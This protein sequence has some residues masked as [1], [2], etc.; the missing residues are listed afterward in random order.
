MDRDA[1]A[2]DIMRD[3][4]MGHGFFSTKSLGTLG[5]VFHTAYTYIYAR[6]LHTDT[7]T[8]T[9]HTQAYLLA[10]WA[11]FLDGSSRAF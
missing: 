3:A 1:I 9:Q 7:Q 11:A 10:Q 6:T 4:Y 5:F 8:H 2:H